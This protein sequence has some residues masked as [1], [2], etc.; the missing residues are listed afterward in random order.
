MIDRRDF[1][2]Q[3]TGATA[4]TVARMTR[5]LLLL[6]LILSPV[7]SAAGTAAVASPDRHGADV[8]E[9]VLNSGGNAVDAAIAT[10]F[11]LAVT[12]PEAGNLGGGGFATVR[13]HGENFFLDFRETAPAAATRD[14][15]LD[16]QGQPRRDASQIGH[17][18][19]GVPG[20]VAGLW[21]LHQRHGSKPWRDLVQPAVTLARKGFVPESTLIRRLEEAA[22]DYA[23]RTN[24]ARYFSD[25][26]SRRPFR[27]SQ[28]ATTLE[29]IA[30][31]GE[32]GFY[33]G[34]T[35]HLIE[36]EMRR[37]GGLITAAD[38]AAYRAV[39]RAPLVA[40]WRSFEVVTAPPPSSG[41]IALLQ[42]LRMKDALATHFSGAELNSPRY[43]HLVAEMS[44]RVFA[45]RA[46]YLGDPDFI[47]VP[48]DAL[49]ASDYLMRRAVDIRPDRLTSGASVRPGL[50]ESLQTTH[51][52]ILDGEGNAVALTYTLNGSFGN[53]VVVEGA[54]FLLNNEMDDFSIKP[55]QPNLYGVVGGRANEIAPGKRMLS[56]M[57][58]TLLL[59]NGRI[60]MVIGTPGGSTIFTSV[61]QGIVNRLD[62]GLSAADAISSARFHH[63]LIPADLIVHSR[64]CALAPGTVEALQAMGYRVVPS[65]WEFGDLQIIDVDATGGVT[66]AADPRGRGAARVFNLSNRRSV[67]AASH[68][69]ALAD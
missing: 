38:L 48:I 32:R 60:R 10:A 16:A 69:A 56:S 49:I 54:G 4:S 21:A 45:D 17:L 9:A 67:G 43:V 12:Y 62:F 59:E 37:G 6:I 23:G 39:W 44:K 51:F 29:R 11:V 41:G 46:E 66:A 40:R 15:Y 13:M 31:D 30:R 2:A 65:P 20:T 7:A 26:S 55:G 35:A 25:V 5:F 1:L 68:P 28:L 52:S 3:A 19:A 61:F 50:A 64:C 53:G 22:S 33:A 36:S 27:Q 24:F 14:M 18:A 8:A 58:P 42:L 63:Q 57:T 47:P 34:R